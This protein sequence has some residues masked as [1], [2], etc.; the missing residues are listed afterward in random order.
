MNRR[1]FLKALNGTTISILN[2][3]LLLGTAQ[4]CTNRVN[5]KPNIIYIL[6]DDLG[7]GDLGCYGQTKIKTPN[8]D[9]MAKEGMRFT[10]HYSGSTVCA[11]SRCT[12]MTGFHTG[13]SRVRGNY[14][15]GPYGFGAGLELRSEDTTVAELL[16]NAGYTTGLFGK[17]GLGV[18]GTTG[19]P[20]KKGFDEFFGY[21]N[22]GQAH[23][24]Y[25]ECLWKN[26][27]KIFLAG[28]FQGKKTQYSHD[29]ITKEAFKFIKNN[30]DN[31]ICLF[32][33]YTIP[34]AEL[35]VPEDSLAEYRGKFPETHYEN[36]GAGGLEGY[37]TQP[38]PKAAF[39]A[40]ITRMDRDI[41]RLF[42][43]LKELGI[44]KN[45]LVMFSSDNGPH[46]EGGADPVFFK[47]S[48]G[49]RGGKRD[50]YEG[51]I[52]V[53]MI[54][55]WPSHIKPGSETDHVSAF[56]DVLPTLCDVAG[57][58]SPDC[59]GLSFLPVLLG[60]QQRKHD[61]LYWEFHERKT[62]NFA[63]RFGKW[64]AIKHKP[65]SQMELYDLE[66]DRAEKT[67]VSVKY[68]E[69]VAKMN[70]FFDGARVEHEIWKL[71]N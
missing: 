44:D 65:G 55:R 41:G 11:P 56:W 28:N 47:S 38:T 18:H 40:M 66:K 14:E 69:I 33:T 27:Q 70:K 42:D 24:Y 13:H 39:A 34:H 3:G 32:L 64:K 29:L 50:L 21:L 49:L 52:R 15:K 31:P 59:D 17:W 63:I 53:P 9:R 30:K 5:K 54:A 2:A 43:L 19:E 8:L 57:I 23:F 1:N 46:S 37:G 12:L 61:F 68:P 48:G 25:P 16:K 7:Y 58:G 26:D 67:D 35:L 71:K 20:N 51:G 22:Q 45:T 60:R 6:A 4:S 10:D 62:T 36:I